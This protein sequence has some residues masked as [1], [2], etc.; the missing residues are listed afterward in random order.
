MEKALIVTSGEKSLSVITSILSQASIAD[1]TSVNT[2]GEARR[3]LIENEY[4]IC[5]INSPLPDETGENLSCMIA[6][7]AICQPIIIV[8][9]ENYDLISSRVEDYGVLTV[10][11]PVNRAMLWTAMKL[12][13]AANRRIKAVRKENMILL[14]KIEDIRIVDRAKCI[15]V[16]QLSMCEPDAHRYIEKHAM[17]MRITK[18]E[19]AEEILKIY[20]NR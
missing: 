9:N 7:K 20:E 2:A 10:S 17:D 3:L 8:K 14:R 12:A 11:K 16:S 4:D 1:I 15:L 5:I 6:E 13:L 19:A 18:R